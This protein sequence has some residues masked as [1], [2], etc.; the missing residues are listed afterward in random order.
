M[1][2]RGEEDYK[3]SVASAGCRDPALCHALLGTRD[4][5]LGT[6]DSGLG[7]VRV[8]CRAEKSAGKRNDVPRHSGAASRFIGCGTRN[9]FCFSEGETRSRWID[10]PHPCGSPYGPSALP[11]FATASA[12]AVAFIARGPGDAPE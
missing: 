12:F 1:A 6:R 2:K 11:M 3:R 5:G 9:P 10:S 7:T 4:S 8:R